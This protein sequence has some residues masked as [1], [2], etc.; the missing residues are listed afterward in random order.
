MI[1]QGA[2]GSQADLARHLGVSRARVTQVL[3]LLKLAPEAL[4]FL[5]NLGDPLPTAKITERKLRRIVNL[6]S[7]QQMGELNQVS[8]IIA[9]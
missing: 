9:G 2:H 5:T 7:E 6:S 3:R 1:L 8:T 4:E